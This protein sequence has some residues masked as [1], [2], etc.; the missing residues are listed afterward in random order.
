MPIKL[1]GRSKFKNSEDSN[2]NDVGNSVESAKTPQKSRSL[3]WRLFPFSRRS[4]DNSSPA[5]QPG[6]ISSCAFESAVC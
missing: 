1:R 4:V 6:D 5:S 3:R 2:H